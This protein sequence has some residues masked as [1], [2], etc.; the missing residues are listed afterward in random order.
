MN[1]RGLGKNTVKVFL[2]KRGDDKFLLLWA[3]RSTRVT[4]C[5]FAL[6]VLLP[7]LLFLLLL[8]LLQFLLLL[9]L[10]PLLLL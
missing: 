10:L 8:P 9:L 7:H 2:G 4:F 1:H 3:E 6:L 5:L